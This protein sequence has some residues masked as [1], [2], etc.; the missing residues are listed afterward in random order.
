MVIKTRQRDT[1]R[2]SCSKI[3]IERSSYV[4]K[5]GNRGALFKTKIALD[6]INGKMLFRCATQLFKGLLL[7]A[8]ARQELGDYF[9]LIFSAEAAK[10]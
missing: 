2:L 1:Y 10:P 4:K 5:R 7:L 9:D 8:E 6:A 3:K